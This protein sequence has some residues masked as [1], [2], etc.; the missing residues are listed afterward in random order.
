MEVKQFYDEPLA[1]ASYAVMSDTTKEIVLIDPGRNPQPY[2]DW[3]A[4]RE[5]VIRAVIET[6][7][8]AD[9]VS[10][11]GEIARTTGAKIYQSQLA[12]PAYEFVPFD[13]GKR[14]SLGEM[15]L[16]AANTPGHSPD[17]ISVLLRDADGVYCVFTG[18]TLF[19]GDVGRPDLREDTG[20]QR[21]ELARQMYHS[22]REILLKLPDDVVIFPAHGAGTLCGKNLGEERSSTMGHERETNHALSEM[23][24]DAFVEYL[25]ADQPFVPKY[26]PFDV[27][28]NKTGAPNLAQSLAQVPHV[29]PDSLEEGIW[30]VDTRPAEEFKRGHWPKAFNLQDGPKFETWLGSILAPGEPFYLQAADGETLDR[31]L[32]RIAKIGYEAQVRGAFILPE[33]D[34]DASPTLRLEEFREN[35]GAYT[36]VDI[37]NASETNELIFEHALTIPLP[38]L[39]ERAG[40]I[41]TDR[42]IVVHCA[43]GYRSAAGSSLLEEMLDVPVYDLGEAVK[44][45]Q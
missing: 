38:E 22:T 44:E 31:L 41:P 2:Y 23:T 3:A 39:R 15:L 4:E 30:I 24:E 35:P 11:H 29:S 34:H 20:H 1:H 28:L 25:L 42:P 19:V 10:S 36:I 37:R 26:F 8:H 43:G 12:E 9:F 40:E 33:I 14:I 45:C 27:E 16:E 32:E 5:G 7:P 6:H 13:S 21:E 18:D 17:S